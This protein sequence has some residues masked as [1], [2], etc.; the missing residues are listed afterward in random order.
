MSARLPGFRIHDDRSIDTIHIIPLLYEHPPPERP[1]I[2]AHL[3]PVRA[4]VPETS[5][6]PV[7]LRAGEYEPA[8][9]AERYEFVHGDFGHSGSVAQKRAKRKGRVS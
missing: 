1:Y 2:V 3:D 5:Q 8:A 7:Y 6:P 4:I 9:L